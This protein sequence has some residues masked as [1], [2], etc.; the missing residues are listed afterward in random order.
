MRRIIIGFFVVFIGIGFSVCRG[1]PLAQLVYPGKPRIME[2]DSIRASVYSQAGLTKGIARFHGTRQPGNLRWQ[3]SRNE[4][5]TLTRILSDEGSKVKSRQGEK[6]VDTKP[7]PSS[8]HHVSAEYFP[9][10]PGTIWTYSANGLGTSDVEVL[11]G[12]ASVRGIETSIAANLKTGVAMCYT[13]DDH[14]ILIHRQLFPNAY[15]RGSNRGDLLITF[16]PPIRVAD[17]IVE[18]GRTAYS[19]GTAEYALVSDRRVMGLINY[20]AT[21]TLQASERVV[22]PA[23]VFDA[24]LFRGTFAISGDVESEAFYMS[25]G[26]GLIK[27]VG[28]VNDQGGIV[29]LDSIKAGP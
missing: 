29:E 16:V 23:G 22:V 7:K 21:Y 15:I 1:G 8:G 25:K 28:K 27:D 17:G 3:A 5:P 19:V 12:T 24:L 6:N 11:A 10:S 9:A 4:K 20:A 26:L 13:S 18:I 14:G 2:I